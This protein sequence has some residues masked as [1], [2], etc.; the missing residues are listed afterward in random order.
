VELPRREAKIQKILGSR[1]N[2]TSKA[3]CRN[4]QA[5]RIKLVKFGQEF[6][7]RTIISCNPWIV[8]STHVLARFRWLC[9]IFLLVGSII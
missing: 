9:R 2:K 1:K 4:F 6:N 8:I 5:F 7:E 3:E